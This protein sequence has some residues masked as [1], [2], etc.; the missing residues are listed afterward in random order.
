MINKVNLASVK[1]SLIKKMNDHAYMFCVDYMRPFN[2]MYMR[3]A[4]AEYADGSTSIYYYD[5]ERYMSENIQRVNDVITEFG[6]EG[7]GSDLHKAGQ[8]AEFQDIELQV[9][10]DMDMILQL[11]AAD[12]L[13]DTETEGDMIP[14]ELW[15]MVK[16]ALEEPDIIDNL[17][18]DIIAAAEEY[19]AESENND[20]EPEHTLARVIHKT[21]EC[22]TGKA[23]PEIVTA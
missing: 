18:A 23:E 19:K 17:Y 8:M 5:I 12:F 14:A 3:D 2:N 6:W 11:A 22:L 15:E 13:L 20:T 21:A 4:I 10:E 9:Y 1:A 7:C 16:Y